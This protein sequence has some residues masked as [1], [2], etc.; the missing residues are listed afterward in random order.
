MVWC[1]MLFSISKDRNL[2]PG[3]KDSMFS[4]DS[5]LMTRSVV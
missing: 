4:N 5:I 3:S 1:S 2:S